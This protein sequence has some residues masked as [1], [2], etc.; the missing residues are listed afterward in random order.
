LEPVVASRCQTLQ[1][2]RSLKIAAIA[3]SV[4]L[5]VVM[6]HAIFSTYT[7]WYFFV[8]SARLTIDG[9]QEQGWLHRGNH[10]ETLFVTRRVDGKAD[11]YMI[12]VPNGRKGIVWNCVS[13]T[14]PRFL[15]FPIGDVNPPCFAFSASASSA[16][17]PSLPA[18]NLAV[19]TDF[20]KFTADDG[21]R[22][23]A[24]W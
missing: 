8:P 16:Q 14:A 12:W 3:L 6:T 13:W 11:S 24:S 1:M 17:K 23:K 5:V 7:A 21:S 4:F 10:R 9:R 18:R 22:I 2:R 20:V 19:G 15:V